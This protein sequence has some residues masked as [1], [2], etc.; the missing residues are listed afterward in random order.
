MPKIQSIA[1]LSEWDYNGEKMYSFNVTLDNNLSGKVNTKSPDRWSVGDDVDATSYNDKQGNKCLKLSKPDSGSFK[2]GGGKK[3]DATT[4]K[5]ITFLSCLNS[6]GTFA[7][8]SG[9]SA[10]QVIDLAKK[11]MDAAYAVSQP[12]KQAAPTEQPPMAAY[13]AKDDDLPF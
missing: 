1:P 3:M 4:E 8:G 11:F 9:A 10:E 5:R 12:P 2:G 13:Q 6:A 7:N